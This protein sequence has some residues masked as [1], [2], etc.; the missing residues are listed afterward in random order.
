MTTKQVT[1][2]TGY[3]ASSEMDYLQHVVEDDGKI[4]EG[5]GAPLDGITIL[6][7]WLKTYKRRRWDFVFDSKLVDIAKI[8]LNTLKEKRGWY[9]W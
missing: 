1:K 3:S 5:G 2:I 7:T 8:N 6:E 9:D 4:P